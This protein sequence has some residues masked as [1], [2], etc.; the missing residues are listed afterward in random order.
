MFHK[1]KWEIQAKQRADRRKRQRI[2]DNQSSSG[3]GGGVVRSGPSTGKGIKF[4]HKTINFLKIYK[5]LHLLD[6]DFIIT[7]FIHCAGTVV[8]MTRAF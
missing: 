8:Q 5:F 7:I 6:Q 1:K 4:S 3:I 2:D